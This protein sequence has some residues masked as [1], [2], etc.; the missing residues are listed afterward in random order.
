MQHYLYTAW[1]NMKVRCG[2]NYPNNKAYYKDKGITVCDEWLHDF[3][4]FKRDVGPRPTS[5]HSLDRIDGS[6][7]YT[8]ENCRWATSTVQVQ[9]SAMRRELVHGTLL[10]VRETAEK[11]DVAISALKRRLGNGQSLEQAVNEMQPRPLVRRKHER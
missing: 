2:K 11:Y 10:S 6:K 4:Q 8:K 7:G 3:H 1:I 5:E 9:N